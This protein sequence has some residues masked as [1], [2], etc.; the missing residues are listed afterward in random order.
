MA[1]IDMERYE[2]CFFGGSYWGLCMLMIFAARCL[3][4]FSA[5]LRLG[6]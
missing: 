2:N 4:M 6:C 1:M 3:R 5:H